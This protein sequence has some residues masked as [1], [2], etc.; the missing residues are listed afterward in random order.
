VKRLG[1]AMANALELAHRTGEVLAG[2]MGEVNSRLPPEHLKTLADFGALAQAGPATLLEIAADPARREKA[3][4]SVS[5]YDALAQAA[6]VVPRMRAMREYLRATGLD[7]KIGDDPSRDHALAALE[8]ECQLLAVAAAPGIVSTT[9]R[10]IDALEARFQKF[11]WTYVQ[12][13]RAAHTRWQ[14]EIKRL[15]RTADDVRRHH[16]ALRRLN[17]I[18]SLGDPEDETLSN[19]VAVVGERIVPC[20]FDGPLAPETNPR[21]PR[22]GYVLDTPSPEKELDDVFERIRRALAIKLEILSQSTIARLIRQHDRGHRLDGF[23]KITQ[24]AQTD[25][26]VQ[27]LDDKLTCYLASLLAENM[28]EQGHRLPLPG[29]VSKLDGPRFKN[30]PSELQASAQ[31]DDP[32]KPPHHDGR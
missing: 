32:A 30:R 24:A 20:D 13:Y 27:V 23:L 22:C 31:D 19:R 17:F 16:E 2:A 8:T 7:L 11:K 25:A 3:L 10:N 28:E 12:Y 14:V 18:A 21:C 4:I 6:A 1:D 5:A 15:S 9:P 26:L 29:T